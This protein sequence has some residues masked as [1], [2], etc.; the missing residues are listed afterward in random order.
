[1]RLTLDRL[2][3]H[4]KNKIAVD[5]VSAELVPGVYGFLGANGAGK[6][7]LMQMICGI[8]APTSGEV[9]LNG[10]NNV[11]MGERFRDLLGYLPQEFGYTPGFSAKD[12]M[13]YVASIKGLDPRFARRKTNELLSLVNLE[14]AANQ[15]IRTFSGGMKRRLGIAQARIFSEHNFRDVKRQDHYY[16]NAHCFGH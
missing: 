12:F 3:K 8:I 13:L 15:K 7:T 16:F 11:L 10:E 9:L 6:T 14:D 5:Q 1:M 2:S 4:F